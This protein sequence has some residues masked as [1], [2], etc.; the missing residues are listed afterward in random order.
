MVGK[1][2]PLV[3]GA[4]AEVDLHSAQQVSFVMLATQRLTGRPLMLII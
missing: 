4:V 2:G 3:R 1:T